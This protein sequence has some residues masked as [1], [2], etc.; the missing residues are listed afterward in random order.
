MAARRHPG[1]IWPEAD[2]KLR[3]RWEAGAP[4]AQIGRELGVSSHAVIGRAHR[5]GL[6]QH[7]SAT[8][9]PHPLGN[10]PPKPRNKPCPRRLPVNA[11]TLP[12]LG[13][14]P[15]AQPEPMRLPSGTCLFISGDVRRRGWRF[16]GE[17]VGALGSP[18]C[19][20]HK[21]VVYH[22]RSAL[23]AVEEV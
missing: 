17:P 14:T 23:R 16:C 6:P 20:K 2:G 11:A 5:I 3:E 7:V 8:G 4:C 10:L 13:A 1:C 15:A 18:W 21:R 12:K 19:T 22:P 9:R